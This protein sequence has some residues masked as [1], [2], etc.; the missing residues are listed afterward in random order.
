MKINMLL[1]TTFLCISC[2]NSNIEKINFDN[3]VCLEFVIQSGYPQEICD[4]VKKDVENILNLN[5]INYENI[6]KLV[7]N[8]VQSNLGFGF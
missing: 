3:E 7:N 2:N 4:C 1:I 6:E 8:C 5:D